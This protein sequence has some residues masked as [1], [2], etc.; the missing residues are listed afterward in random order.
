MTDAAP[1]PRT[2]LSDEVAHR[3]R[4]AILT[5][6]LK[7]GMRIVQEEWARQLGVSRMPVRDAVAKLVAEGLLQVSRTNETTVASL[8]EQ[9]VD[10]AYLVNAVLTGIAAQR[11]AERITP[12]Q[13][14]AMKAIHESMGMAVERGDLEEAQERNFDF[15]RALN[16]ACG[17]P[18]LLAFLRVV[19]G[20]IPQFAIREIP[21]WRRRAV[22]DHA[23]ILQ[24]VE[25]RDGE[26]ARAAM[27]K[28]LMTLNRLVVEHLRRQG[29][30]APDGA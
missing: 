6:G 2:K 21:E 8:S 24:A 17:S 3:L 9:D 12:E 4:E 13:L 22:D 27:E 30:F 20:G 14:A 5:G 19:S 28:H 16:T 29:F 25:Q 18:R 15:H 1:I 7:P 26:A 23:A 10:D 11:T